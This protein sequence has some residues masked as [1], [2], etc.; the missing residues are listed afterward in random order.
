MPWLSIP[1]LAGLGLGVAL[2][3]F[4]LPGVAWQRYLRRSSVLLMSILLVYAFATPGQPMFPDWGWSPTIEG[5]NAGVLQ[6]A[7]L[8]IL[9]LAL[10]LVLSQMSREKLFVG[11]YTLLV[12]LRTL[13][14]PVERLAG[15]L[16]L[17]LHYA[18]TAVPAA[19]W[20]RLDGLL[21]PPADGPTELKLTLP[22]FGWTDAVFALCCIA[23]AG[24]LLA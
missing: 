24:G 15:R 5:I 7:R 12:P 10:A 17:T 4:V 8:A 20:A 1:A 16:W 22:R 3:C 11:V 6:T 13:G 21:A 9:L 14:L 19:P 23:G 18:D 2:G